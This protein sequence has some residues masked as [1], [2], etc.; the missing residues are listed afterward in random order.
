MEVK[1]LIKKIFEASKKVLTTNL[2]EKAQIALILQVAGESDLSTLK[3]Y[4]QYIN[5]LA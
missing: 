3:N 1:V 5:S 4:L 2:E